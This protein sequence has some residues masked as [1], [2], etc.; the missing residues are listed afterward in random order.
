MTVSEPV[1][2]RPSVTV[3][4]LRPAA[5]PAPSVTS[6]TGADSV[7]VT[8]V[9]AAVSSSVTVMVSDATVTPDRVPSTVTVSSVSWVLLSAGVNTNVFVPVC[10]PAAIGTLNIDGFAAKPTTFA[11]PEPVTVTATVLASANRVTP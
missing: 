1:S 11:P 8:G 4:S 2:A 9:A 6:P 5:P 3:R 7:T 10:A